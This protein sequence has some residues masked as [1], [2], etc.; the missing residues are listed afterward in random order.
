MSSSTEIGVN[1]KL[2]ADWHYTLVLPT[3][4]SLY[5]L[6]FET[7]DEARAVIDAVAL[8]LGYNLVKQKVE[9]NKV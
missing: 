9:A 3:M 5:G 2:F 8:P 6:E 1:L 4:E 7:V